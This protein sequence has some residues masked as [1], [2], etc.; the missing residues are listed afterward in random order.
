MVAVGRH[1][2]DAAVAAV[3]DVDVAG[4]VHRDTQRAIELGARRRTSVA[5]EARDCR[6]RHARENS[7][8]IDLEY[9]VGRG[10][11]NVAVLVRCHSKRLG[12]RR[13]QSG[14]RSKR[15]SA[16]ATVVIR[17]CA[18]TV[19]PVSRNPT[20]IATPS[21]SRALSLPRSPSVHHLSVSLKDPE[22][23][24]ARRGNRPRRRS[25]RCRSPGVRHYSPAQCSS[26]AANLSYVTAG[27]PYRAK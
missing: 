7:R 3:G 12:E 14:C 10:E 23:S 24:R 13:A 11:V 19:P 6:T 5:P 22:E 1:L 21:S 2:A 16:P 17:S 27:R 25:H 8:G 26:D 15:Q 18:Q 4:A 20:P 9:T